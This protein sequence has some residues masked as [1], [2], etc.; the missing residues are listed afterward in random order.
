MP[1]PVDVTPSE[2]PSADGAP[3]AED[4]AA[5]RALLG[6]P[7]LRRHLV[8]FVRKRVQPSDVE[9]V[10]QTVLCDAL[11]ADRIPAELSELRR[12]LTGIARHKVADAHRKA[13]REPPTELSDIEAPPAPI[14]ERELARWAE[15]QAPSTRDAKQTLGWMAREGEGEKLESIAEDEKVPAARVRQRVSRL[16]RWMKER[17]LAELAAV[18]ALAIA[19]L[20]AWW[21]LRRED[22][23]PDAVIVP[24]VPT[25]PA[26]QV[27]TVAP[28]S[29]LPPDAIARARSLRDDALGRCGASAWSECLKGL[30]D[31]KALDPAG[32]LAPEIQKA[33]DAAAKALEPPPPEKALPL[34]KGPKAPSIA[35]SAPTTTSAP[36]STPMPKTKSAKPPPT[37]MKS[38]ASSEALGVEASASSEVSFGSKAPS[39]GSAKKVLSKD[40]WDSKK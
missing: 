11:A 15:R 7:E 25:A 12:W 5:G 24:E 38:P 20:V 10:V 16:R 8:E 30:D 28:S 27:P 39:K 13:H 26:P 33:R 37:S 21:A 35:P 1:T 3:S 2:S 6:T 9:D 29:E 40:D 23:A 17:W 36:N 19:A 34:E 4:T 32:D 22:K 18:A 14:E 31:A